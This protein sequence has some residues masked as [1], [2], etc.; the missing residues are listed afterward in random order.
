MHTQNF[1]SLTK[2]QVHEKDMEDIEF[3]G[4]YTRDYRHTHPQT[5]AHGLR[6]DLYRTR[7]QKLSGSKMLLQLWRFKIFG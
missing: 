5:T 6:R 3:H 2:P 1:R 7:Q 4:P